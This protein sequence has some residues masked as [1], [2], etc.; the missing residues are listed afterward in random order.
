[1]RGSRLT[2]FVEVLNV[3]NRRNL[4]AQEDPDIVLPTLEVRNATQKLFPI[5]PSAGVLVEF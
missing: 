3:F 4:R 1:V 5:V 2:L